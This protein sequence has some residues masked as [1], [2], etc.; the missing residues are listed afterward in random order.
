MGILP[1]KEFYQG[2][3]KKKSVKKNL[4]P[5]TK[6]I[7]IFTLIRTLADREI[8]GLGRLEGGGAEGVRDVPPLSNFV[9]V[10]QF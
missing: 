10:K 5:E 4:K 9:D 3:I 2:Y 7:N 8:G 1:S 6:T